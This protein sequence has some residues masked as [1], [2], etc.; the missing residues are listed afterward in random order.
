MGQGKCGI[1]I[2]NRYTGK[3]EEEPICGEWFLRFAYGTLPGRLLQWA[4]G[5]R[6]FFSRLAAI[7][8]NG[9]RSAGKILPFIRR[10]GIDAG[11]SLIPVGQ[12]RTFNDF[13]RR[14]LRPDA[15]PIHGS[16]CAIIA[17]AD[18]RYFFI[19]NLDRQSA[20][21][22]KG[23]RIVLRKLF[24]RSCLAEKFYGGCAV[25]ARLSPLDYH[26]FHFP[27]NGLPRVAESV[28]GPLHSVHPLA[29]G[30]VASLCQNRRHVT[31]IAVADGEMA[32]VE[33]GATFI[34]SIGQTYTANRHVKKGTEK[35]FFSFG[36][37]AILLFFERNR[38]VPED[39]I[40]RQ[41]TLGMETYVRM[42]DIILKHL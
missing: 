3:C 20:I 7:Y 24:G 6:P 42:G 19:P 36:G 9:H 29:L 31:R 11:E 39:D 33:V 16:Q 13:F 41:S 25:I 4:V 38:V 10:Y 30:R 15:R 8:A 28:E 18:G 26:R 37:S 40:A 27:C 22:I 2:F 34:G 5:C 23:R 14:R 21:F 1:K 17:P 35:G 32:M 12:F